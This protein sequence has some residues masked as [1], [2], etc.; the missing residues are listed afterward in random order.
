MRISSNTIFDSN[1][2]ALNQ[3]QARLQ[4]TQIQAATGRRLLTAATDP[5]AATRAMDITQTDAINTQQTANRG[6]ARDPMTLAEGALQSVT[7]LLQD[8]RT[9]AV[10]AGNGTLG[11]SDRATLAKDL[12]GRLQELVGLANSTDGSGNYL[13][14]GF[15]FKTPPFVDTP[16]GVSYFGDNGQRLVQVSPGRQMA[17]SDNGAD[18]FMRIKNGNGTFA[19]QAAAGNTGGGLISA[20]SVANPA[21]LVPG[22]NYNITFTVAPAPAGTTYSATYTNPTAVPPV[23]TPTAVAGMTAQPY[24]SGQAIAFDGMQFD[25]KG[26]PANG[27]SFTVKPSTNQSVFKTLSDLIATLNTPLVGV[28]LNNGLTSSINNLDNAL[29]SVLNTRASLGL[30]LNELDALQT[31]GDSMSLQLKQSLSILQDTDYNKTLS[32][33]TQQQTIMQ[34]AQKSFAQVSNLSLFTYI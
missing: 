26:V 32:D 15:Q 29:N 33:L 23:V 8:A 4:Q 16:A 5:V 13:F 7:L 6:A 20:G 2:A 18:V 31:T 10:S 24:A 3:Q 27:D 14:S 21:A 11:N 25:I 28:N 19:T 34:A 1:V 30:R 22:N 12:S 17:V 9:A